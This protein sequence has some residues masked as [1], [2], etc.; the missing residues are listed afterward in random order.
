MEA[1]AIKKPL[2]KTSKTYAQHEPKL[3]PNGI[4]E[5]SQH[6][7]ALG[8]GSTLF[9]GGAQEAPSAPPGSIWERFADHFP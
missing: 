2:Q 9:Q 5:W 8:L 3:I 6:R 7:H 1:K 4:A